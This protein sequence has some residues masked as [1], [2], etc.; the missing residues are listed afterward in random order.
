MRKKKLAIKSYNA[1][2]KFT[3]FSTLMSIL[4]KWCEHEPRKT[5]SGKR[6]KLVIF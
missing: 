3:H 4:T 1:G 5:I 6:V 2:N